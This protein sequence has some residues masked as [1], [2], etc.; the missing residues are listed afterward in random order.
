MRKS[1]EELFRSY[2]NEWRQSGLSQKAW[3]VHHN[4]AYSTFHYW[5]RR[6]HK[7]LAGGAEQNKSDRFVSLV[8]PD[9]P[10]VTPW[11]ELVSGNGQRLIFHQPVS[12]EFI[13]KLLA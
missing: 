7:Q 3:C 5:N 10:A 6:L 1:N 13:R 12:A 4:V 9:Q 11:C 2:I 8:I